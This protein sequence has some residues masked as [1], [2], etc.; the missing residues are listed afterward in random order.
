[1]CTSIFFPIQLLVTQKRVLKSICA[2]GAGS[3][4]LRARGRKPLS[5]HT[6]IKTKSIIISS[7]THRT[8]SLTR[9]QKF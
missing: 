9:M 5:S 4:T 6:G 7:E 2:N 3:H 1:M 8:E